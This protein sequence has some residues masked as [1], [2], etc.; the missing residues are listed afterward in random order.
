MGGSWSQEWE[1]WTE[2]RI[3]NQWN[4][5]TLKI[6]SQNNNETENIEVRI[7]ASSIPFGLVLADQ[8]RISIKNPVINVKES[9]HYQWP[10]FKSYDEISMHYVIRDQTLE[11]EILKKFPQVKNILIQTSKKDIGIN[12]SGELNGN[13]LKIVSRVSLV[14]NNYYLDINIL[15]IRVNDWSLTWLTQLFRNRLIQPL[16]LNRIHMFNTDLVNVAGK[17][18][19]NNFHYQVLK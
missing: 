3:K 9:M 11:K 13:S 5:K 1:L 16:K 8:V 6:N 17:S 19:V 4:P 18:G 2:E 10:I 12:V 15:D 14:K 7:L